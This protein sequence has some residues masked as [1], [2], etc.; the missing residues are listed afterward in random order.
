MLPNKAAAQDAVFRLVP[1]EEAHLARAGPDVQI[2][3]SRSRG[4]HDLIQWPGVFVQSATM[5][6]CV[7]LD[8]RRPLQVLQHDSCM[9]AL[10]ANG[11]ASGDGV[12]V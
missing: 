8:I 9:R 11:D 5:L 12:G 3:T 6:D 2:R 7:E 1:E 4:R 10:Q